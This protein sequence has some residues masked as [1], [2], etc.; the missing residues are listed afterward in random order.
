MPQIKNQPG[1]SLSKAI[2][3][4]SDL[5]VFNHFDFD[6]FL[7]NL[8]KIITE[9]IPA[10]S[11]LIYF[12]DR[13]EKQV[14]LIGSKKPHKKQLG[15]IILHQGEG[16]TGWVVAHKEVVVIKRG[17]YKDPRFKFFKELPEDTYESFM[18]IPI[19]DSGGVVGVI[20]LQN[21]MPY[22]FSVTEVRTINSLVQLIA[23]AFVKITLKR[24]VLHLENTLEE[25]KLIEKAK[26]LLMKYKKL[27]EAQ[28]Y[29]F[30]RKESMNR[31]KSMRDIAESII[32]VFGT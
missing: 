16:I 18:S 9:I 30:I 19:L 29:Q 22:N 13:D 15:K 11:I 27:N 26:G 14:I 5:V 21:R 7:K 28:S 8:I 10:D 1:N 23:S 12:H 31:R 17:A 4:L 6:I 20:N 25:R 24:R 3:L 2:N 32:I